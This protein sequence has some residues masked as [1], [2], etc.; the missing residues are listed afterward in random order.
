MIL[1]NLVGRGFE[2]ETEKRLSFWQRLREEITGYQTWEDKSFFE[3][4]DEHLLGITQIA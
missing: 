2:I 4:R 3:D 1:Y